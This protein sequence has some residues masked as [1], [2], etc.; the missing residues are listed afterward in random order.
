V[1]AFY[2]KDM[3]LDIVNPG[4]EENAPSRALSPFAVAKDI[5]LQLCFILVK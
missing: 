1:G 5:F 2:W 4:R 3:A